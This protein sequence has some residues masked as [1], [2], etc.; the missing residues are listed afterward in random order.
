MTVKS[1]KPEI[2]L[3]LLCSA[4]EK[5][6]VSGFVNSETLECGSNDNMLE[7]VRTRARGMYVGRWADAQWIA[8]AYGNAVL[9]DADVVVLEGRPIL[10]KRDVFNGKNPWEICIVDMQD[11]GLNCGSHRI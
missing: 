3:S 8:D 9:R 2:E 11:G 1:Q 6:S 7:V 4:T 10:I 5:T